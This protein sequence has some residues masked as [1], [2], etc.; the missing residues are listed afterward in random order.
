VSSFSAN[1]ESKHRGQQKPTAGSR[2]PSTAR[3]A[4]EPETT[5]PRAT[6]TRVV[7]K[8]APTQAGALKLARRYGAALVCVRHRHDMEGKTRFTTVELVVEQVSIGTKRQTVGERIV[9]IHVART[10]YELKRRVRA[11]G[12]VWDND[13]YTWLLPHHV[14]RQLGLLSRVIKTSP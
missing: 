12:G 6:T 5:R 3:R 9:G 4:D 7:K 10:E 1:E 13:T 11:H 2:A 8:L 14:A